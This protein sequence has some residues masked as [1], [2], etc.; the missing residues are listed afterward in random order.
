RDP[1]RRQQPAARRPVDHRSNAAVNRPSRAAPRP[2]AD[3]YDKPR[4]QQYSPSQPV[5]DRQQLT[6]RPH[7][8]GQL[9]LC[10][11][12]PHPRPGESGTTADTLVLETELVLKDVLTRTGTADAKVSAARIVPTDRIEVPER[13]ELPPLE[14]LV[15]VALQD[16]PDLETG[17][18]QI[19][20]T[21]LALKG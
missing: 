16:R 3:G 15:R 17:Q 12:P 2:G 14:E 4:L 21:R 20:N 11:G 1:Q 18:V 10:A 5:P 8:D 9:R 6:D 19:E 7:A 13:D